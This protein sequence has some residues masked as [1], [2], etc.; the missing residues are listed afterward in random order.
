MKKSNVIL[1][2]DTSNH[3]EIVVAIEKD[4][5]R[6]EKKSSLKLANAQMVLPLIEDLMKAQK[7]SLR[8]IS[9]IHVH[10]GPGSFTGLRVGISVANMLANVLNIPINDLPVGVSV[11][12]RYE[13]SK[14][15]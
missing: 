10:T 2:V 12:P 13:S 15:D 3:S 4:G 11:T 5:E 1:F 6:F 9:K 14:F 8:D 7:V